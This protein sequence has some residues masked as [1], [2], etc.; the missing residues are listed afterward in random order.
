MKKKLN[1]IKIC[2]QIK[3]EEHTTARDPVFYGTRRRP[4]M[5]LITAAHLGNLQ[6]TND[7][8]GCCLEDPTERLSPLLRDGLKS[9]VFLSLACVK[10]G[11]QFLFCWMLFV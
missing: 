8:V 5:L 11:S 4:R 9:E 7:S 1:I 3:V 2:L 6:V 10:V